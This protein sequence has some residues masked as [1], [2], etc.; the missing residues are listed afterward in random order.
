MPKDITVPEDIAVDAQKLRAELDR[1]HGKK[2]ASSESSSGLGQQRKKAA[3][4]LGCDS[5]A[6]SMIERID[7]KSDEKIADFLRSFRPLYEAMLPDWEARMS[8]L[9]SKAQQ[10][11]SEM[12]AELQE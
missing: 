12:D 4:G 1:I 10:D 2:K 11:A 6:L 7:G 9:F 3:E 5:D 8:D